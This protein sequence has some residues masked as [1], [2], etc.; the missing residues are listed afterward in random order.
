MAWDPAAELPLLLRAGND[1]FLYG[2]GGLP[3]EQIT[4]VQRPICTT[5]SWVP[6]VF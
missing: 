4:S 1:Y 5:T 2:P 6:P 3:I